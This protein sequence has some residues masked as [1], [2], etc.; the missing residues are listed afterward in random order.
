MI[1]KSG[2]NSISRGR[3][4]RLLSSGSIASPNEWRLSGLAYMQLD[5]ANEAQS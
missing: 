3:R 1:V 2:D 4:L 5:D